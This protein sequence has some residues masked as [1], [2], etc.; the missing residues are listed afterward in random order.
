MALT[1]NSKLVLVEGKAVKKVFETAL[2]EMDKMA[3]DW[4]KH[5]AKAKEFL[6]YRFDNKL[7]IR[8]FKINSKGKVVD[9]YFGTAPNGPLV[10]ETEP[11]KDFYEP[12]L[13]IRSA[14]EEGDEEKYYNKSV[15]FINGQPLE[16][17]FYPH[18]IQVVCPN[19]EL[20]LDMSRMGAY[21]KVGEKVQHHKP[22]NMEGWTYLPGA[23]TWGPSNE[24]HASKFFFDNSKSNEE[25]WTYVDELTGCGYKYFL[26][27]ANAPKKILKNASRLNNYGTTMELI[28]NI[29]LTKDYI[30]VAR[31]SFEAAEDTDEETTAELKEY[32]IVFGSNI[33]DGKQYLNASLM[34]DGRNMTEE[35]A[36]L[37][38]PQTR[39][40]TVNTKCL[41]QIL[42]DNG[43]KMTEMNVKF[44]YG[45]EV[46]VFGNTAGKCMMIVDDDGA[47]LPN[48]EALQ[49]N[50]TIKV[51]GLAIAK[52]SNSRTSGQMIAKLLDKNMPKAIERL[53]NLAKEAVNEQAVKQMNG[54]F[55]PAAGT[56]A[57]TAAV[58]GKAA[59]LDEGYAKALLDET[60]KFTK[61][62]IAE[63]KINLNS[64]YNHAMFDDIFVMSRGY[65]EHILGIKDCGQYGHLVEVF[66]KDVLVYFKDEIEEIENNSLLSEKE[67]EAALDN[68]LSSF[69]IK[70]PSAGAE[71]YLGVRYLTL[72]EWRQ[73]CSKA[74]KKAEDKILNDLTDTLLAD[75]L[76]KVEGEDVTEETITEGEALIEHIKW[77]MNNIPFGVT[78]FAAF[79]FIK[80]K[81]AGMD[82]D[83]DAILAIF[84]ECK[85]ILLTEDALN[86]LT[87]IDYEDLN[88]R[89]YSDL[90]QYIKTADLNFGK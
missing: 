54:S 58:L 11:D 50:C 5:H 74:L 23:S 86:V 87:F 27:K 55:Y 7:V 79:N 68:L 63:T 32:G 72:R 78:L 4:N 21:L 26:G 88:K 36:C 89:D 43:M 45:D 59:L 65:I 60:T 12:K 56:V 71:E 84:D 16:Y 35:E 20:S 83:F 57:N 17:V 34:A 29:D 13:Q 10:R 44:L 82:V 2:T 30:V 24:K 22:T 9:Q 42:L 8:K 75:S 51:Y 33:N 41:S 38:A 25:W 69:I 66:S 39:A 6:Q 53:I 52:A 62:A 28:G 49:N 80:N 31:C 47:K 15:G 3:S 77:Y 67:R 40:N 14:R 18:I 1:K 46:M 76:E 61:S 19:N 70:Y 37:M 48:I 81:L 90:V 85:E 64:V 73:R